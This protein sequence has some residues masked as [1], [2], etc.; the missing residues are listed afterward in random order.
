[1][2]PLNKMI[3]VQIEEPKQDEKKQSF[4]VTD[5]VVTK[6]KQHDVVTVLKT[7]SDSKF[8]NVLTYGD[9]ILVEAHMI[10]DVVVDGT[11]NSLISENNVL[12]LC[13]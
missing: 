10:V 8:M 5:D 11:K 12:A 7:A 4:F 1:M 13:N 9:K 3:L 6:K 2:T